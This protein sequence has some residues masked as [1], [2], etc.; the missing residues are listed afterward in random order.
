M[1]IKIKKKRKIIKSYLKFK[2]IIKINCLF[3]GKYLAGDSSRMKIS[4]TT[5][6]TVL[7]M[8]KLFS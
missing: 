6:M 8:V 1:I 5:I 4:F 3:P 2:Y 7:L